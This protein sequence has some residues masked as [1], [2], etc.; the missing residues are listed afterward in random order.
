MQSGDFGKC[1]EESLPVQEINDKTTIKF[2]APKI[3]YQIPVRWNLILKFNVLLYQ[4]HQSS[5]LSIVKP[6]NAE[7][8]NH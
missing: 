7:E 4:F 8:L 3:K 6:C 2:Q 5:Y 1:V